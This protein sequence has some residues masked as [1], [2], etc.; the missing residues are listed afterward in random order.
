[1]H[2]LTIYLPSY[3]DEKPNPGGRF[4][5]ESGHCSHDDR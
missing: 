1:M 2:P 3:I 5:A 4:S